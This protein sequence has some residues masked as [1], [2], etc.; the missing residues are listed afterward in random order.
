MPA[1]GGVNVG[2]E[3][4]RLGLLTVPAALVLGV[5]A[6]WRG[7]RI[8]GGLGGQREDHCRAGAVRPGHNAHLIGQLTT[9]PATRSSVTAHQLPPAR[10]RPGP[11][12]ALPARLAA[13][14][15]FTRLLRRSYSQV[16]VTTAVPEPGSAA[17]FAY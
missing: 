6:L 1:A 3:F 11:L 16:N 5:L 9:M 10:R 4:T 7:L 14:R 12:A 8:L 15:Y 13:R 17:C 2:G